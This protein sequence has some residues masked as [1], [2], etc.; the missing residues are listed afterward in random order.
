M[1][2]CVCVCVCVTYISLK[3][4]LYHI[5]VLK[6]PMYMYEPLKFFFYNIKSIFLLRFITLCIPLK[7][8]FIPYL[9]ICYHYLNRSQ[10]IILLVLLFHE[11]RHEK[12]AILHHA[13][14]QRYCFRYIDR[15]IPILLIPKISR[16]LHSSVSIQGWFVSDL[17]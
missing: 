15:T 8:S 3:V 11:P 9:F 7:K 4:L 16:I 10:P 2:V 1:C 6:Y 5:Y 12:T 17:L 13:K 14:D